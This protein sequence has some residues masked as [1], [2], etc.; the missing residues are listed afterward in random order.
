MLKF[1]YC[2]LAHL[3]E[4]PSLFRKI[5]IMQNPVAAKIT[6]FSPISRFSKNPQGVTKRPIHIPNKLKI[7][8]SMNSVRSKY[9]VFVDA[10]YITIPPIVYKLKNTY[11]LVGIFLSN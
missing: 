2:S 3:A 5:D 11:T 10:K 9:H 6:R 8:A 4:K 7:P 1:I